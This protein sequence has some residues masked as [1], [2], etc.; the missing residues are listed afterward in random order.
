VLL[1][2]K[3]AILQGARVPRTVLVLEAEEESGS[4]DLVHLLEVNKEIIK[5]PDVCICLDSGALDYNN[6]W[7]TSTLR[8]MVAFTIEVKVAQQGSHSGLA[9]GVIPDTWR[10]LNLLLGRL[11]N[12]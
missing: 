10:I 8:G 11:E 12:M 7:L 1:A 5:T 3:N 9:G 4:K 2:L 6:I